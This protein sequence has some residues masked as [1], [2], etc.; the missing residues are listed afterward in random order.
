M[1]KEELS[2]LLACYPD[3]LERIKEEYRQEVLKIESK[4]TKGRRAA[5]VIRT[6]VKD[7]NVQKKSNHQYITESLQSAQKNTI[8]KI[9]EQSTDYLPDINKLQPKQK[10]HQTTKEEMEILF[11]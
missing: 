5:G 11:A 1:H 3:G 10:K 8:E 4:N 7:Y 6:K 2:R 9:N